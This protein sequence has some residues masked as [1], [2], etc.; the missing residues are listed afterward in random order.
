MA[1]IDNYRTP[2]ELAEMEEDSS[3][4]EAVLAM[5]R[6]NATSTHIAMQL[7]ESEEVVDEWIDRTYNGLR[8]SLDTEDLLYALLSFI[9]DDA[10]FRA[11]RILAG[12]DGV[13]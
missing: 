2:E 13:L 6:K 7:D 9:W 3:R 11:R 5:A 12:V 4:I 1:D 10:D 8:E